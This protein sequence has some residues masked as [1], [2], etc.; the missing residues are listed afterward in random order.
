MRV[1]IPSFT[2]SFIDVFNEKYQKNILNKK[3]TLTPCDRNT[4]FPRYIE[5]K[6]FFEQ[7]TFNNAR[8]YTI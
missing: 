1:K 5:L 4:I 2:P 3:G 6:N 7:H 8:F